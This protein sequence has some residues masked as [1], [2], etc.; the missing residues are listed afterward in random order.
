MNSL[1]WRRVIIEMML[2]LQN[3]I[4]TACSQDKMNFRRV[5][6]GCPPGMLLSE[7]ADKIMSVKRVNIDFSNFMLNN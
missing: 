5:T 1:A 2:S 7:F 3:K 6:K 4:L